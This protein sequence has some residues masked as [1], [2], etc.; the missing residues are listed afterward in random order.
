MSDYRVLNVPQNNV[1]IGEHVFKGVAT[2]IVQGTVTDDGGYKRQFS[3][4]TV[5]VPGMGSNLFS[6]TTAMQKGIGTL[7]HPDKPRVEYDDVVPP[8]N[9][10]ET[11]AATGILLCSFD[12]ELGG[13][14][15]G[16]A[17]RAES[18]DL[19]HRRM[20]HINRKSIDVL[21]KQASNGVEYNGDVQACDVCAVQRGHTGMR[22]LRRR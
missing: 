3:F 4:G 12:L 17:L 14:S 21:R 1:R 6:V 2:G 8:M 10:L 5:V 11:D 18:A 19:W 15:G 22:C 16:L 13:D 20:A 7:F 9:V